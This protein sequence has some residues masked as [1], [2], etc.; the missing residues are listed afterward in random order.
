MGEERVDLRIGGR[1]YQGLP[2]WQGERL[3]RLVA[4]KAVRSHDQVEAELVRMVEADRRVRIVDEYT[5]EV[6]GKSYVGAPGHGAS[7]RE[8]IANGTWS[9]F[10]SRAEREAERKASKA[11]S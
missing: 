11:K 9:G 6:D 2:R 4:E 5:V 8:G 7:I 1:L 3:R 10:R